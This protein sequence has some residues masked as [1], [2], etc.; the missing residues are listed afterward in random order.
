MRT[1]LYAER[2]TATTA[3]TSSECVVST[4]TDLQAAAA[5]C[6]TLRYRIQSLRQGKHAASASLGADGDAVRQTV[7]WQDAMRYV[8]GQIYVLESY[9]AATMSAYRKLIRHSVRQHSGLNGSGVAGPCDNEVLRCAAAVAEGHA[10]FSIALDDCITV[11]DARGGSAL[12]GAA[13]QSAIVSPTVADA[14]DDETAVI[15]YVMGVAAS[16]SQEQA[17]VTPM[18]AIQCRAAVATGCI[19]VAG[20]EQQLSA[21]EEE[22]SAIHGALFPA[23]TNA[24]PEAFP[25]HAFSLPKLIAAASWVDAR[26]V[27][28]GDQMVILPLAKPPM[29]HERAPTVWAQMDASLVQLIATVDLPAG[30]VLGLGMSAWPALDTTHRD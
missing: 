29:L 6:D 25:A 27:V 30:T 26:N 11:A 22:L 17:E 9:H 8:Q 10:A 4:G 18:V 23:L 1:M 3:A 28:V 16:V 19:A 5:M 21:V 20:D 15:L 2:D 13:F 14:L 7:H 24:Y 12:A